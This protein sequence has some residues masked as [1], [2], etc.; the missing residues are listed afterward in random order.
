MHPEKHYVVEQDRLLALYPRAEQLLRQY[1]GVLHVGLGIKEVGRRHTEE[2]AFRVYVQKK[3]PLS[4]LA[5]GDRIPPEIAGVITDVLE[6]EEFDELVCQSTDLHIDDA[7]YR[8]TGLRG[9][10]QIR[11]SLYN[12]EHPSGF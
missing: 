7:K 4:G 6:G 10:I 12:N 9:G 5:E 8:S 3:V 11:N 1:P 2:L